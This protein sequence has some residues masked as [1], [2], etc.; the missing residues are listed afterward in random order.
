MVAT[1][2][3]AASAL[4][5][6]DVDVGATG[7][8][9]NVLAARL[10]AMRARVVG[11]EDGI[12]AGTELLPAARIIEETH[13]D[14]CHRRRGGGMV[15]SEAAQ[16]AERGFR[17]ALVEMKAVRDVVEHQSPLLGEL[18]CSNSPAQRRPDRARRSRAATSCAGAGRW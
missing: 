11:H 12:V 1:V 6:G 14:R 18:V 3:V 9:V 16:L 15:G 7:Q 17:V 10:E 2:G 4:S 13:C 5:V 8:P